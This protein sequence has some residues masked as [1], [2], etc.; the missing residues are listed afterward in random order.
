MPAK[1][2][3]AT[4]SDRIVSSRSSTAKRTP[5]R[6]PAEPCS[7]STSWGGTPSSRFARTPA[8]QADGLRSYVER[9]RQEL[10]AADPAA[11]GGPPF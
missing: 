11:V 8:V 3:M 6:L 10:E 7:P 5:C 9:W 2:D 4:L 1:S